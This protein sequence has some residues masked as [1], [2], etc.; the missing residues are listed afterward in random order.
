MEFYQKSSKKQKCCFGFCLII[1]L[2]LLVL[3]LVYFLKIHWFT[4]FINPPKE[5][6]IPEELKDKHGIDEFLLEPTIISDP[7]ETIE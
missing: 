5:Q 6:D 4:D 1:A 3:G 7:I 2:F